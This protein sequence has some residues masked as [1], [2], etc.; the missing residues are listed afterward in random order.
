MKD[1]LVNEVPELFKNLKE[2]TKPSF[3][4]MTPQHMVE[5]LTWITKVTTTRKG[6]PEGEPLENKMQK[7][8]DKGCIFKHMPHSSMVLLQKRLSKCQVPLRDFMITMKQIL[9][10]NVIIHSWVS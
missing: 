8:F 7:F 2:D 10:T 3:G 9:I 4:I 5:H 1:F 6:V